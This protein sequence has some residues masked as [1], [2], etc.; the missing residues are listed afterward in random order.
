MTEHARHD[1]AVKLVDQGSVGVT[2]EQPEHDPAPGPDWKGD[3]A[4]PC[5]HF[6][7]TGV[8]HRTQWMQGK[9][10]ESRRMNVNSNRDGATRRGFA[11]LRIAGACALALGLGGCLGYDGTVQHGYVLDQRTLDQVK[12][13]ATAQ[14]VLT[15]LGTPS[16]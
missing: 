6:V 3:K 11:S 15:T 1:L 12:I 7:R 9:F 8:R 10:P 14:Q 4:P 5:L 16:T 2:L 13:G